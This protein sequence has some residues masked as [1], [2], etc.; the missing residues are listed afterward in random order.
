MVLP[1]FEEARWNVFTKGSLKFKLKP[2]QRIV[3]DKIYDCEHDLFVINCARRLGKSFLL[4]LICDEYC[5]QTPNASVKYAAPS[6]KQV[7]E[8]IRPIF[9]KILRDCPRELQ[10]FWSTMDTC[11]R[12]PNGSKVSV[13]GCDRGNIDSLRGEEMNFG[14][15]DEAGMID[16]EL[17]YIISDILRPQTLTVEKKHP[18]DKKIILA[19][20][21]PV[22]PAHPFVKFISDAES[23]PK[24]DRYVHMTIYDNSVVPKKT[25]LEYAEES[26]CVVDWQHE[27]IIK[28]STTFRREYLAEVVTEETRSIIPEFT[29]EVEAEVVREHK[30]PAHFDAYISMDVGMIDFT[31]ALFAYW[32]FREAKLVVEDEIAVNYKEGFNTQTLAEAIA[33]KEKALWGGRKPY[34]RVMDNNPIMAQDLQ[35]I[36]GL[37][38]M[39][40]A[41]D[42]KEAAV[43]NLRLMVHS[44]QLIINPRCKTLR[45]HLKYGIWDKSKRDFDRSGE[46]GHFDAVDAAIYL[47]RNLN[48]FRNPY[49]KNSPPSSTHFVKPDVNSH[50]TEDEENLKNSMLKGRELLGKR[51]S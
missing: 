43:N 51:G 7:R 38:F 48:K 22:S 30:R 50:L 25:I 34:L 26:G 5:R 39:E 27:N 9:S 36:H 23:D 31:V 15:I 44:R 12:Y 41:K 4:C 1:P 37:S 32:D 14:V 18:L 19:S 45:A 17:S 16:E 8:I 29:A 42:N 28:L 49:P 13:V 2:E 33:E 11:Y 40:S 46:F 35:T 20:T 10:P 21:P 24:H 6:K 47:V 3:Y